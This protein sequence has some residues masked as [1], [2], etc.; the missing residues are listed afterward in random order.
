MRHV[1][2]LDGERPQRQDFPRLHAIHARFV[3]HLVLFKPSLHQRERKRGPI[4]RH[5]E[6]RQQER[7]RPDV[8]L[9]AMRQNQR[10]DVL[11]VL[12]QI[13]EIGRD[14]IHA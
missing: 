5:V 4:N 7:D 11:G 10:A 9:M 12:F 14:D 13:G 2:E 8:I 6:L 3:E 1:H